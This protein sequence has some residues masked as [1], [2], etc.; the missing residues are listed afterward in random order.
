MYY[1]VIYYIVIYYI[2]IYYIVMYYIVIYYVYWS[3]ESYLLS[4]YNNRYL[5]FQIYHYY[6][7]N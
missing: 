6:Y 2:V 5:P 4:S 3:D 7:Y 1:I